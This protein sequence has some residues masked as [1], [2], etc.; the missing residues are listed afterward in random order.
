MATQNEPT[1]FSNLPTKPS[2]TPKQREATAEATT[3]EGKAPYAARQAAATAEKTEVETERLRIENANKQAKLERERKAAEAAEASRGADTAKRLEDLQG[4]LGRIQY[5]RDL[6]SGGLATG[7]FSQIIGDVRGT[8]AKDLEAALE[9]LKSPIVLEALQEARKG[10]AVGATGFGALV[11]K[12]LNLLAAKQGSLSQDQ[13]PPAIMRT[14]NEIDQSY[15]R[16]MA[17]TAGYDPY[18]PEGALLVGLPLPEGSEPAPPTGDG[19]G[20][21]GGKFVDNPELRGVNAAV[22]S[23]I[24]SGRSAD[25]IRQWLNAYQDG[26]GERITG[27][28]GQIEYHKRTGKEPQGTIG[29]EFVPGEETL[30]SKLGDNPVGAGVVAA[31]D[32][33]ASGL[34][35]E[36]AA[37][38][39]S[40]PEYEAQSATMRGLRTE[41]PTAS[42][43]GD[44][45]GAVGSTLGSAGLAAKYGLR[46]PGLLEG[47]VQEGLYGFGS[48]EPGQRLESGLYGATTA[49]F[50][51]LVGK[52]VA[53]LVGNVLRGANPEKAVLMD[54]GITLTPGQ[55]TGREGKE[56]SVA[57]LPI[58]GPQVQARRNE[59]LTQFNQAAFDEALKPIGAT[60][61][62]I[63]QKGIAEAQNAV[64]DAYNAALGGRAFQFDAPFVQTVR[65]KPYAALSN[66][67]GDLGPK[68]AG[69]IDRILTE[70]DDNGMAAGEAWQRARRQ[71]VDLQASKEIKDDIVGTS[72]ANNI[73]EIIDAFDELVQR[74]APDAFE[75]YMA[76]NAAYRNTK[77]LERAVDYAPAGDVFG[78]GNLRSATRIGTQ[79]FGGSAASA[80][81]DRPFNELVMSALG[82]IPEKADDVS[83]T[84][85]LFA[86][87]AG[88]TTFGGITGANLL[89]QPEE[90]GEERSATGT[91]PAWMLAA[92]LGAGAVSLPYSRLGT[93]IAG[94]ALSGA[95]TD[96]QRRIGDLL[97][98]Y[99][100]AATRGVVRGATTEPGA[101]MVEDYDYSNAGS[102]QLREV[103][104][105]IATGE[106]APP[107]GA[108]QTEESAPF[109][110]FEPAYGEVEGGPPPTSSPIVIDGRPADTVNGVL[111]FL[112]TG[113][114]VE[115]MKRGGA[116]KG[117]NRGGTALRDRARSV[118]QGVTFGFGDEIEGGV[119]ALGSA[120]REGDLTNLR[121]K[122][123]QER[124]MVRAQQKAYEDANLIESLLYEGG[125]AMLTG[126]LPGAQGAT[127]A[128]M[129]Q[130]A[131]RS[132]KLARAAGVA[133]DTALYGAGTAE[134]VRD[135]PRSIRDE[136][137]LAVPM[138][139]AAE[140]V[141]S[142]VNRYRVRKG[143]KR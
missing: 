83:M 41:Y 32:Q 142:G 132:P 9:A 11:T 44:V 86:P 52:P 128:R 14:L 76:A 36:A 65:G 123:L 64:T 92:G 53:D 57:G 13:S 137:L 89:A 31:A 106:V 134:S 24:K 68:A 82:T 107:E 5:A 6:V 85:R 18:K 127:A 120:L 23:M 94:K 69:E 12:E 129:A 60:T 58:A 7:P 87:V 54:R 22:V 104:R 115:R 75:G 55:L 15:R 71:L 98:I 33:L 74:Q 72:V 130:L 46:L 105:Q 111:T 125:G 70:I 95:R 108:A 110:G 42:A 56:R 78:P 43:I 117:Y 79:K 25:Q 97:Q 138:Y 143:K 121:R 77:T 96:R 124:D 28:E 45:V 35:G 49:P 88:A 37:G 112:D 126:L 135:I 61:S 90:R 122:Y 103:I 26:L 102:P 29:R 63:G 93:R 51:N 8:S 16:I 99:G 118:G 3:A 48:A 4:F 80:R 101:P 38:E 113:E 119:R 139:G 141:R 131:A 34:L 100:P 21:A 81:G 114:P 50:V 140:G 19:V 73:G 47:A 66:M 17:Y 2:Q 116:V 136:A 109:G 84:G 20:P 27:L 39:M 10:S 40:G 62:T 67:K 1:W 30:I 133:A 59:S 91:I